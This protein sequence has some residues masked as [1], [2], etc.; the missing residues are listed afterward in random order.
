MNTPTTLSAFIFG[1]ICDVALHMINR[2]VQSGFVLTLRAMGWTMMLFIMFPWEYLATIYVYNRR[3]AAAIGFLIGL[4]F[5][6]GPLLAVAYHSPV[7]GEVVRYATAPTINCTEHVRRIMQYDDSIA[8]IPSLQEGVQQLTHAVVDLTDVFFGAFIERVST[9]IGSPVSLPNYRNREA[10]LMKECTDLLEVRWADARSKIIWGIISGVST[11]FTLLV[12]QY[13]S[14]I[15]WLDRLRS[16]RVR[17]AIAYEYMRRPDP[18]SPN[19]PQ[20]LKLGYNIAN[21][22]KLQLARASTITED[23]IYSTVKQAAVIFW[24]GEATRR[25]QLGQS[26]QDKLTEEWKEEVELA[27]I[28]DLRYQNA[29]VAQ[30]NRAH[31]AANLEKMKEALVEHHSSRIIQPTR[32][33]KQRAW[34][35]AVMGI[36]NPRPWMKDEAEMWANILCSTLTEPEADALELARVEYSNAAQ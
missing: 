32:L 12:M 30:I 9:L 1:T 14:I 33:Q 31:N 19:Y 4:F 16:K 22:A 29:L 10:Q 3:R 21:A 26:A 36:P 2:S 23:V 24:A 20:A 7:V 34:D 15:D 27:A 18:D 17:A 13:H 35:L 11:I 6:T 5:A 28:N 8:P 25:R